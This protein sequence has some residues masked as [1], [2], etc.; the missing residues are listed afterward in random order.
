[1]DSEADMGAAM[2]NESDDR[3]RMHPV[4]RLPARGLEGLE[5]LESLEPVPTR[6]EE[7]QTLLDEH[8]YL[9][10]RLQALNERFRTLDAEPFASEQDRQARFLAL[11]NEELAVLRQARELD[12]DIRRLFLDA[13]P[14]RH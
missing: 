7:R 1:M 8:R 4:M 12:G 9:T 6:Q 3:D 10:A 14:L 5:G 13:K 11:L 2:A